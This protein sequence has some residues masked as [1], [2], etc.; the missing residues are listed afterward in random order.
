M[1]LTKKALNLLNS[2]ENFVNGRKGGNLK[3]MI[4][5]DVRKDFP[6]FREDPSLIYLDNAATTQR[7]DKVLVAMDD[8]YRHGNANIHRGVYDLSSRATDQYEKTRQTVAEF[9][10]ASSASNIGFTSGTTESVNVIANSF[11]RLRL[12]P[13]DNVVVSLAEHHANF[14]P[15]QRVCQEKGAEFRIL[16]VN[17]TGEIDLDEFAGLVDEK[18]KMVA[19]THI[20]NTLGTIFPI[21]EIISKAHELGVPVFVD[22]A[23]S[24]ALYSL[25][26]VKR[27]IDFLA[28][29]GHKIF[30][31]FGVGVIYVADQYMEEVGPYSVGGGMIRDVT[32]EKTTFQPFPG[33]LEAGTAN[34]AGVLGMG[35]AIDYLQSLDRNELRKNTDAIAQGVR[36]AL[37]DIPGVRL[38]GNARNISSIISFVVEGVHPHDAATFL[39]AEGIAVRAGMHC[40]QP[41]L[42]SFA[43]PGTVRASFTIYN[44]AEEGEKLVEAVEKLYKFW[45]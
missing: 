41:L 7:P 14:I 30:G 36:S 5:T 39:N 38:V 11:L 9:I 45:L 10:G 18:T 16:S 24:A 17:E 31:P 35:A 15:W 44:T 4:H 25:D 34:I 21:D 27:K 8:F 37:A 42:D 26:V 28:F 3:G 43:L 13:G 20:S 33:N 40:T 29:S 23:Q 1:K 2:G 32:R 6:I 19:V 22:A 12:F